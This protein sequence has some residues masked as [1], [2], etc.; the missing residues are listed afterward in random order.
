MASFQSS[1]DFE[2]PTCISITSQFK[3]VDGVYKLIDVDKNGFGVY[4]DEEVNKNNRTLKSAH[5]FKNK[6]I[7]I[8]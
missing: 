6:L 3:N 7:I 1:P 4:Y 2:G 5:T 8:L